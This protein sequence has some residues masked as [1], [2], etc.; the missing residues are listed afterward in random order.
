MYHISIWYVF[1]WMI[2]LLIHSIL[3]VLYLF[4]MEKKRGIYI[5]YG[6][7]YTLTGRV[8]RSAFFMARLSEFFFIVFWLHITYFFHHWTDKDPYLFFSSLWKYL[9][10]ILVYYDRVTSLKQKGYRESLISSKLKIDI[11][12]F[13]LVQH[14]V[15]RFIEKE[16]RYLP[17]NRYRDFNCA[18]CQE[19]PFSFGVGI[20]V[21]LCSK[22][23][24][25]EWLFMIL[26][27]KK[28][29]KMIFISLNYK[30][31]LKDYPNRIPHHILSL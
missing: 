1:T 23:Y 27:R 29:F 4:K 6:N 12:F 15:S 25:S 16:K 5:Y 21:L 19:I 3:Y 30:F 18:L 2:Y 9:K 26:S 8:L 7:S 14:I 28:L 20:S 10:N 24:L 22:G 31:L 13:V 17:L 11:F